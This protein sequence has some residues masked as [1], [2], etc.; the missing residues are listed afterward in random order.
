MA[1]TTT[2]STGVLINNHGQPELFC[3]GELNAA[4]AEQVAGQLIALAHAI[5]EEARSV[6]LES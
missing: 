3:N 1:N 5:R 4:T 6:V 2:F